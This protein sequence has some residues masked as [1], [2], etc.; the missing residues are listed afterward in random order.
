M[1]KNKAIIFDVDGTVVDSPTQKLPTNRMINS[2]EQVRD[3]YYLC[4]ATGRPWT[5]AKDIVQ[6][7][8]TDPCIVAGGTQIRSITGEVLWECDIPK[9]ALSVIRDVIETYPE[10][11]LLFNDYEESAYL[12]DKGVKT[13]DIEWDNPLYFLELIFVPEHRARELK[14]RFDQIDGVVCTMVVAQRES[15]KDL[16]ITNEFATKEHAIT[17]LL[18]II[19]VDVDQTI[20]V[21]MVIMIYTCLLVLRRSCNGQCST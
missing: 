13:S 15:M 12:D 14:D 17:E 9:E 8:T 3:N 6:S 18:K 1:S 4:A 20:G 10:H 5:F 11:S 2:F 21:G 16:H 7:L 19:Q